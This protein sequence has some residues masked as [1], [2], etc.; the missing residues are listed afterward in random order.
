MLVLYGKSN[1]AV[2]RTGAKFFNAFDPFVKMA[3]CKG[4]TVL[5]TQR[6]HDIV[7]KI[8]KD[9]KKIRSSSVLCKST[10]PAGSLRSQDGLGSI[11]NVQ[12]RL[13]TL[14]KHINRAV[15]LP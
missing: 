5:L 7:M 9:F 14:I 2:L 1:C 6:V 12:N 11:F 13:W 15:L 8:N 10:R 4:F 3:F